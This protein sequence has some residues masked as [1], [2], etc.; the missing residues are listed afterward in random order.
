MD[1]LVLLN[2]FHQFKLRPRCL[3]VESAGG[4]FLRLLRP[5]AVKVKKTVISLLPTIV[6]NDY[7]PLS[8]SAK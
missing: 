6:E 7:L 2:C 4:C 1:V 8:L 3:L 5:K